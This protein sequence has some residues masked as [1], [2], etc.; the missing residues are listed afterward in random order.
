MG[1][2]VRSTV[3]KMQRLVSSRRERESTLLAIAVYPRV[4]PIDSNVV[5]DDK[6]LS[7]FLIVTVIQ[8]NCPKSRRIESSQS[9]PLYR[10]STAIQRKLKKPITDRFMNESFSLPGSSMSRKGQ[11]YAS[12]P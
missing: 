8:I 10:G 2:T 11:W 7:L 6:M 5:F 3:L 9:E 1:Y 12:T 4:E